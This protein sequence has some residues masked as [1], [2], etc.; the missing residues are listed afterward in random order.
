MGQIALKTRKRR[1][2]E[3]NGDCVMA[4][5]INGLTILCLADGVGSCMRDSEASKYCCE[6]FVSS[7][8]Q[9]IALGTDF[10]IDEMIL[11]SLEEI[12]R[13]LCHSPMTG[14][15]TTFSAVVFREDSDVFYFVNIGDSRIYLY[16]KGIVQF[17]IDDTTL[18]V[19]RNA[20]GTHKKDSA[21]M[22]IVKPLL[23]NTMGDENV[24]ITVNECDYIPAGFILT[25]D[26][27]HCFPE[28]MTD[29]TEVFKSAQ[30][31][32]SLNVLFKKYEAEQSD[33]MSILIYRK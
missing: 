9:A 8:E 4:K 30:M 2:K 22:I 16:D 13:S 24:T 33:D 6:V 31:D 21:G 12:N 20:D 1:D 7:F 18:W 3:Q 19:L 25:S 5:T 26:G 32:V 10:N 27:M 11:T 29:A 23:T 15:L 28:F 14:M 17:T